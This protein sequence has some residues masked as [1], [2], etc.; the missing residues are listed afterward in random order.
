MNSNE[1]EIVYLNILN[2]F[3]FESLCSKIIKRLRWGEVTLTPKTGDGGK[4][5]IVTN[6][7]S[8]LIFVECKNYPSSR[9]GRPIVQKLHSAI[10]AEKA[11]KGIVITSGKFSSEAVKYVKNLDTNI[12]LID[13]LELTRLGESV[14]IKIVSDNSF[15]EHYYK[16]YASEPEI[17]NIQYSLFNSVKTYPRRIEQLITFRDLS[18]NFFTIYY[19]NYGVHEQFSTSVGVVSEID[20]DNE[21]ILLKGSTGGEI[22]PEIMN[23]VKPN[24][25]STFPPFSELD[26]GI[27]KTI[28]TGKNIDL[29]TLSE[30]A[31]AQ[32]IRENT[33]TVKYKGKINR[34][35]TKICKPSKNSIELKEIKSINVHYRHVKMT[36]LTFEKEFVCMD[37]SDSILLDHPI[38][39]CDYCGR[40]N[41]LIVCDSC[42]L[43][44]DRGIGGHGKRC[45]ICKK[46]VCI[47]C[48]YKH[49]KPSFIRGYICESCSKQIYGD[50]YVKRKL[51]RIKKPNNWEKIKEVHSFKID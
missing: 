33:H 11:S 42:S 19:I 31:K 40:K 5:I 10:I 2:G 35:Y 39:L 32:I 44:A 4:D 12:E 45:R 27:N 21:I 43:I 17:N 22:E 3:E 51:K 23:F 20:E 25:I 36:Q 26:E 13:I 48:I 29:T 14:G 8:E 6:D 16:P 1:K 49:K 30:L 37:G 38:V 7:N 9:I 41:K 24:L 46:T 47:N 18:S 28:I 50:E 15:S 34:Q